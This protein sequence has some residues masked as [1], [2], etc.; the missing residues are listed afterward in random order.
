LI[1]TGVTP[2]QFRAANDVPANVQVFGPW[3]G[4]LDKS[5]GAVSISKPGDPELDGFVPYYRVDHVNYD[6]ITPWPTAPDGNGPSLVR[7]EMPLFGNDP[8]SWMA[9]GA[10]GGTPGRP[11]ASPLEGD[12]NGDGVVDLA[13]LNNVRNNFGA[14]GPGIIGDTDG[15]G[16]V[17]LADLNAV[18]NNFGAS[19]P[20]PTSTPIASAMRTATVAKVKPL[21]TDAALGQLMLEWTSRHATK[22]SIKR[23]LFG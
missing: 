10:V 15:N 17:D 8:A 7:R 4:A 23:D 13:D 11:E 9:G 16:I 12:T 19:T 2:E 20:S 22:R 14:S 6:D 3:G 1:V 21:A 5:G 18:R